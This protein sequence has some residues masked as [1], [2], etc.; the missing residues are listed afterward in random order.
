MPGR[1]GFQFEASV[2]L[3]ARGLAVIC[4]GGFLQSGFY[5]ISGNREIESRGPCR[6]S[7]DGLKRFLSRF[8]TEKLCDLDDQPSHSEDQG[9]NFHSKAPVLPLVSDDFT[10]FRILRASLSQP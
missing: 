1:G 2:L 10:S 5:T 8:S 3:H 4:F 6:P 7:E 9:R